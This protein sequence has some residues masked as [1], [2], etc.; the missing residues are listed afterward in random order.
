MDIQIVPADIRIASEGIE[1]IPMGIEIIPT[2]IQIMLVYKN[3]RC[4]LKVKY[5][6]HIKKKNGILNGFFFN[7]SG[8][9]AIISY[10]LPM[11]IVII[12]A[13]V[14][15]I[16]HIKSHA[17]DYLNIAC[18]SKKIYYKLIFILQDSF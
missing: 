2:G 7:F 8:F 16:S 9:I 4:S 17:A 6:K 10:I 15:F 11:C 3:S 13:P 5:S 18:K 12:L 14:Q 1:N